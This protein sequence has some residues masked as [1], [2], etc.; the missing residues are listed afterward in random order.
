MPFWGA[1][2]WVAQQRGSDLVVINT[3]A[4]GGILRNAF[5]FFRVESLFA[6][7][8]FFTR[9]AFQPGKADVSVGKDQLWMCTSNPPRGVTSRFLRFENRFDVGLDKMDRSLWDAHIVNDQYL[10]KKKK[11]NSS[12]ES[13]RK[14]PS[15]H[16]G[17]YDQTLFTIRSIL[18]T[19]GPFLDKDK[20]RIIY[21]GKSIFVFVK[22]QKTTE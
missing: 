12:S 3:A 13:R 4:G 10:F 5:T 8:D 9:A 14:N 17:W 19:V 21:F 7:N 11:S 15:C 6:F 20:I 22:L 18:C 2:C 1:S 16:C